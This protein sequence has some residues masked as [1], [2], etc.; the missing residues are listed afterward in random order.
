[1]RST[2]SVLL[3]A[4]CSLVH[5]TPASAQKAA[6]VTKDLVEIF[7]DGAMIP[8]VFGESDEA[9]FAGLGYHHMREFPIGTLNMLWLHSGRMAEIAGESYL[10]EDRLI[11]LWEVPKI[12]N[13]HR[14][15]LAQAELLD[16]IRAYVDG[17]EAGRRW[18]RENGDPAQS[19]R[20]DALV[21][22]DFSVHVDPVP[23]WLNQTF[24]PYGDHDDPQVPVHMRAVLDRVFDEDH[25][26]TV[27]HVLRLGVCVNSFFLLRANPVPLQ[28]LPTGQPDEPLPIVPSPLEDYGVATSNQAVKASNGWM[29]SP[30]SIVGG[31]VMTATDSHVVFNKLHI[32]PYFVQ[33]HGPRYQATGITMPG[34]PAVYMGCN[35]WVSWF[36]TAPADEPVARNEWKVTLEDAGV[37]GGLSF[38]Y[39]AGGVF[40][41]VSLQTVSDT[42]LYFDPDTGQTQTSTGTRHYVPRHDTESPALGFLRYPVVPKSAVPPQP[43]ADVYFQQAAF[44]TE[45]SPWEALIRFGRARNATTHVDRI[46]S[47]ALVIFGNGNNLMV[48]DHQGNFRFNDMARIPRQGLGVPA[49]LYSESAVLDG[50]KDT[51][52]W[53]D[54]HAVSE[55]PAI[56]PVDVST[57]QEVWINNN[58]T[59]DLVETSRFTAA[60][61]LNYPEYMVSHTTIGTWRQ[62]RAAELLRNVPQVAGLDLNELAGSDVRHQ[63]MH[64]MW[65]FF[66][67][68][69]DLHPF[70]MNADALLLRDWIEEYRHDDENDLPDPAYDFEAHRFSQVTVYAVLLRSHYLSKLAEIGQ[71]SFVEETSATFG[72]D[73]LHTL[74][75]DPTAFNYNEYEANIDAMKFALETVALLWKQGDGA[76]GLVN[77]SLLDTLSPGLAGSPWSDPRY[78]TPIEPHWRL[79]IAGDHMTRWGHVNMGLLTPHYL[80]PPK[81][82]FVEGVEGRGGDKHEFLKGHF[83]TAFSPLLLLGTPFD[84]LKVPFYLAQTPSVQPLGGVDTALFLP[85]HLPIFNDPP[86]LGYE[87]SVYAWGPADWLDWHPQTQGSQTLLTV[88]LRPG[89]VLA[90]RFLAKIGGTEITTTDLLGNGELAYQER[91]TPSTAFAAGQWR[92]LE[93]EKAKLGTP[94]HAYLHEPYQKVR[95]DL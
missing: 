80:P 20:L 30:A 48:A 66:L 52:R 31:G 1:M 22:Q 88:F 76:L 90:A 17:I 36:F 93:T 6:K 18:W 40:H 39:Q 47:S 3:L 49:E 91:F 68:A 28:A 43:G 19:A 77:Q 9:A 61:L 87:E 38:Q 95:K 73:P 75:G 92:T 69:Y 11:R 42:L 46:F 23:D 14:A 33:V 86:P 83:Y 79:A 5:S 45:G 59:P 71:S 27:D 15:E 72:H 55:L 7:Y 51:W 65:P 81:N 29:V 54:Y 16:L 74:F 26:I 58:V 25:P 67:Q 70:G 60:D 56:G 32:R 85:R 78:A 37:P 13:R 50:S 64:M 41:F 21:G 94:T 4:G 44:T 53:Q 57:T 24:S 82:D 89:R 62:L 2:V 10:D 34:Y 8:H 35:D 84:L 12:A 63:W